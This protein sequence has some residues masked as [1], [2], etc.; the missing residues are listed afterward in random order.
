MI[1]D[2]RK[3]KKWSQH[4]LAKAVGVTQPA[5][6]KWETGL[7]LPEP[8]RR[9]LLSQILDLPIAELMPEFASASDARLLANP[10]IVAG[11]RLLGR[12]SEPTLSAYVQQLALLVEAIEEGKRSSPPRK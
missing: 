8:P 10:A 3:K 5:V 1:R 4:R 6:R 2:A 11:I 9:I 12:L 7:N